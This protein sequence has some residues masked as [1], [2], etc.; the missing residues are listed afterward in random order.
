MWRSRNSSGPGVGRALRAAVAAASVAGGLVACGGGGSDASPATEA[1]T[2]AGVLPAGH[3]TAAGTNQLIV[4]LAGATLTQQ[5]GERAAE[6]ARSLSV[7]AGLSLRALRQT[8]NGSLVLALPEPL[9]ADAVARVARRVA[10]RADVVFAEP[11][12]LLQADLL[13]NDPQYGEQWSLAD[14]G[15]APGAG[16]LPAAWT[17]TAG[18]SATVVAVL[19]N[20]VLPHS[21]LA[22]RLLPGY[23]FVS[24]PL[25]GNDGDGRDADPTDA[26]DWLTGSESWAPGMAAR[27]SSWH[28]TH[29]AGILAAQGHNALGVAGVNWRARVLPVRVLGRGGGYVSDIADGLQWAV[30]ASVPGVPANPTP[31][32]VVNMSLGGAGAC[33]R[34]LQGALD[35]AAARRAV[36]VVSAGN[37]AQDVAGTMLAGC[38]QVLAV[39]ALGRKGELAPYSNFG[40]GIAVAAPGGNYPSDSGILSLGDSG[41]T[42]A[43][44]DNVYTRKQGTSMAAP[45]VAGVVSLML[46]VNP[47]LAPSQ[48]QQ[49]L[50]AAVRPFPT[51]T[52][53]DCG[54]GR[55]GAG[56]L[57]AAAAVS[58]AALHP[59]VTPVVAPVSAQEVADGPLLPAPGLWQHPDEPGRLFALDLRGAEVILSAYFFDVLGRPTWAQATLSHDPVAQAFV[60]HLFSHEGGAT[61]TGT[62]RAPRP[63]RDLGPVQLSLTDT[64]RAVLSWSG[65]RKAL[66]RAVAADATG[67][68]S[69][70][71]WQ[72]SR[73]GSSYW[74]AGSGGQLSV[75][76]Q[77][78]ADNGQAAWYRAD[79][80][81]G[82]DGRYRGDWQQWTDGATLA[83]PARQPTV[84]PLKG[85]RAELAWQG[86]ENATLTL[87]DGTL[88]NLQAGATP[89]RD[90]RQQSERLL[91]QWLADYTV[92]SRAGS[93]RW[94]LGA[95]QAS[96]ANPG[97]YNVTGFNQWGGWMLGGWSSRYANFSLFAPGLLLDDFYV[98]QLDGEARAAGCY[99]LYYLAL[100]TLSDCHP[101]SASRQGSA[102][103]ALRASRPTGTQ[104]VGD[105][106]KESLLLAA[107][108]PATAP[109]LQAAFTGEVATDAG[110]APAGAA[111]QQLQDWRQQGMVGR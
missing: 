54:T 80:S 104:V 44:R 100:N 96:S 101:L 65:A 46:A 108:T 34:E 98:F 1:V 41:S 45:H 93:E 43:R 97:D 37:A 22:G 109:L 69:G 14:S 99:H 83:G 107:A 33:S 39:A 64:E 68:R 25:F 2:V 77:A 111:M 36:V 10:Q 28:G 24:N 74:L 6:F 52:G 53:N 13:P 92:A 50:Q 42:Q 56:L 8:R 110:K 62:Y 66:Q 3:A 11:D 73:P 63:A 60:G 27:A 35:E 4:R 85:A 75:I 5:Y 9:S 21:E 16:S 81:R 12:H 51:G 48:L 20:G 55:C 61:L 84:V 58:L 89:L 18:T 78:Y 106:G 17:L 90:A 15:K 29:V 32:R 103:D 70:L 23:D 49:L 88:L 82:D 95:L 47:A 38:R 91:G 57:D 72:A 19:D 76:A 30:G 102:A 7:E 94:T 71:W 86:S 26:G 40:A 67:G 79:M 31:A 87:P 105:R 59:A